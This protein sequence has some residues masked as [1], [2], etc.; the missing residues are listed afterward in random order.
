MKRYKGVLW[1]IGMTPAAQAG[2]TYPADKSRAHFLRHVSKISS[3]RHF[4][5]KKERRLVPL[6]TYYYRHPI[7]LEKECLAPLGELALLSQRQLNHFQRY[8]MQYGAL[9]SLYELQ[10]IPTWD[11]A[12]VRLA[13]PFLRVVPPRLGAEIAPMQEL[14]VYVKDNKPRNQRKKEDLG[15]SYQCLLRYRLTKKNHYQYCLIASKA[16]GEPV[17]Y[18]NALPMRGLLGY[19]AG[20]AVYEWP[21]GL[22]RKLILGDYEVGVGQGLMLGAHFGMGKSQEVIKVMKSQNRG[23]KPMASFQRKASFRGVACSLAQEGYEWLIYGSLRALDA[24]LK[25]DFHI[26]SLS[27]RGVAYRTLTCFDKRNVVKERMIG[28]SLIYR[29]KRNTFTLGVQALYHDYSV[30][31]NLGKGLGHTHFF[32]GNKNSNIGIFGSGIWRSFH[33]LEKQC[34]RIV[35][36]EQCLQA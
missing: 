34:V 5:Y 7:V 26:E 32:H 29:S 15:T 1:L 33:F 22:L 21:Q 3:V 20:Y 2:A 6:W 35:G 12:T 19:W 13:A 9:I 8:I 4:S 27:G 30:P 17:W 11:P 24:T 28:T 10:R 16:A 36:G 23:I 14:M 18:G 25:K 31:L